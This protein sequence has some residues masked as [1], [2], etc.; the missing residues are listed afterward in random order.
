MAKIVVRV[1]SNL[2]ILI[3]F[4][5]LGRVLYKTASG[6]LA[7]QYFATSQVSWLQ[8]IYALGLSLP[9]A[10]HVFSIGLI[11]QLRWLSP[12]G[13]QA[14]RFAIVVSGCWLGLALVIRWWVL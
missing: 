11:L 2:V 6:V 8:N 13:A 5:L 14:A 4:F 12:I 7:Q 10:F 9:V 3:A 1:T